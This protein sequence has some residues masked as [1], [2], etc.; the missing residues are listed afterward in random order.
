MYELDRAFVL[1]FIQLQGAPTRRR[2]PYIFLLLDISWHIFL[3]KFIRILS[4]HVVIFPS[5]P[6]PG[7]I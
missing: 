4:L 7:L 1:G 3:I 2:S 5:W 6:I